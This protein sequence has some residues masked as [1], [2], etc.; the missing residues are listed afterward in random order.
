MMQRIARTQLQLMKYGAFLGVL[1][2]VA[3]FIGPPHSGLIKAYIGVVVGCVILG[4]RLTK[5][6][7]EAIDASDEMFDE[8]KNY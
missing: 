3:S 8:I 6:L 2:G 4:G 1:G 7:K 5:A